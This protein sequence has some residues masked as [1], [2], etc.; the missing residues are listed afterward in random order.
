[1]GQQKNV[2][3]LSSQGLRKGGFVR[4]RGLG[5]TK[6]QASGAAHRQNVI[7]LSLLII[8]GFQGIK[9]ACG[10]SWAGKN[11]AL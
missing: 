11:G 10:R 2:T 6:K 1:V 8:K 3:S 4:Y 5:H 9:A 7:T